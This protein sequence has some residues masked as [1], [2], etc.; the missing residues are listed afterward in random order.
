MSNVCHLGRQR[1]VR[2]LHEVPEEALVAGAAPRAELLFVLGCVVRQLLLHLL[3]DVLLEIEGHTDMTST[4]KR[5]IN[6]NYLK[7]EDKYLD[8]ASKEGYAFD[9]MCGW[10]LS[11]LASVELVLTAQLQVVLVHAPVLQVG[12]ERHHAHLNSCVARSM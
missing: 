7:F 2:L 4:Q 9:V 5:G 1:R 10:S 3:L 11:S 8:F 12:A 6:Y